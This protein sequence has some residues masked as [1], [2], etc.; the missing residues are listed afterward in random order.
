MLN[1]ELR[2]AHI[3]GTGMD[4]DRVAHTLN[5]LL[6]KRRPTTLNSSWILR[7]A[8]ACYRFI[9]KWIRTEVGG[10][11]WDQVT[12]ILD[13]AYQRRWKPGRRRKPTTYANADEVALILN[14]YREK[15]YVFITPADAYDRRMRDMISIALVRVAQNG[16]ILARQELMK[17]IGY[18]IE[19]WLED[20]PF[21]SRW[22]GYDEKLRAQVE[23]CIRRYRYTGS[24]VHYLY[25]TLEYA[26]RGVRPPIAYSLDEALPDG[27]RR[28]IDLIAQQRK[29]VTTINQGWRC[30]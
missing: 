14:R 9:R 2:N 22:R 27:N 16:N 17:L 21:L 24:F 26:A 7:H 18:T 28:K 12:Y 20:H 11:D 1:H 13:S 8:P 4:F 30:C 19:D 25:K 6:S 5:E 15:L 29:T 23:G 10:I 3:A